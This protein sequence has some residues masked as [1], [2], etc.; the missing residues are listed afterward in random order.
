MRILVATLGSYGA[1]LAWSPRAV[2]LWDSSLPGPGAF[3]RPLLNLSDAKD[4]ILRFGQA[5]PA[6]VEG[7]VELA[8]LRFRATRALPPRASSLP[9]KSTQI[10]SKQS[11]H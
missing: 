6:G 5:E 7:D 10:A 11:K 9:S 8:R 4:G 2:E 1:V 3:P